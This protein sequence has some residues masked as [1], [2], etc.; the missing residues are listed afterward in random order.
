M[1]TLHH[2]PDHVDFKHVLPLEKTG[3]IV[4]IKT[5]NLDP[6]RSIED[7]YYNAFL[8]VYDDYGNIAAVYA[9]LG[10]N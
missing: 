8:S 6:S 9:G 5:D 1:L 7:L 3:R 2:A 10:A 4:H